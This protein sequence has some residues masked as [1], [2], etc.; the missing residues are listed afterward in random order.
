MTDKSDTLSNTMRW[1]VMT[2]TEFPEVQEK[3]KEEISAC[4]EKHGEILKENCPYTHSEGYKFLNQKK[5]H[6]CG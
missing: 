1:L 5:D 4:I 6:L 2:L 3:C